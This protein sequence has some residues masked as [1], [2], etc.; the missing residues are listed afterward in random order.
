MAQ[1]LAGPC[2]GSVAETL[3]AASPPWR[4]EG[5]A[6]GDQRRE[7]SYGT[8]RGEHQLNPP[9]NQ[10]TSYK[11]TLQSVVRRISS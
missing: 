3:G 5:A 2:A 1:R 10:A 8:T 4:A 11:A 6:A 9:G 7:P